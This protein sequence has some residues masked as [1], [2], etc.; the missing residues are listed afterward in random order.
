[1]T[2]CFYLIKLTSAVCVTGAQ[3]LQYVACLPSCT[4]HLWH[5]S[6]AC[7]TLSA[8]ISVYGITLSWCA[9]IKRGGVWEGHLST[10]AE[11]PETCSCLGVLRAGRPA[12]ELGLGIKGFLS[13]L[14]WSLLC[15]WMFLCDSTII[16]L[17]IS[18]WF[19]NFSGICIFPFYGH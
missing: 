1:M 7:P 14:F 2:A 10:W 19:Q 8:L 5:R 16:P 9:G 18:V 13:P 3:D 17:K 12:A 15:S 4:P 11:I 6:L